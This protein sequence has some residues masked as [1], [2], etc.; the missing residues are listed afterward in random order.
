M[1]RSTRSSGARSPVLFRSAVVDE[2]NRMLLA[3]KRMSWAWGENPSTP[4]VEASLVPLRERLS[5]M[6][7]A[8]VSSLP[9]PT[10]HYDYAPFYGAGAP[11]PILPPS[12]ASDPSAHAYIAYSTGPG[13]GSLFGLTLD[14]LLDPNV[15]YAGVM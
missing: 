8:A 4:R 9:L 12:Y 5:L 11:M 15:A 2:R 6:Q 7:S 10:P 3:M 14:N 1:T 13:Q